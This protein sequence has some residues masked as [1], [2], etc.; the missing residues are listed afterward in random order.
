MQLLILGLISRCSSLFDHLEIPPSAV[1]SGETQTSSILRPAQEVD[2]GPRSPC[3]SAGT[4]RGAHCPTA[5]RPRRRRSGR[6]IGAQ[7]LSR[8]SAPSRNARDS[9]RIGLWGNCGEIQIS[10]SDGHRFG[11]ESLTE[12]PVRNGIRHTS[13]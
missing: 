13:G 11:Q 1:R 12:T 7:G 8:P 10:N 4:R 3:W 6:A 2:R 5:L 9:G